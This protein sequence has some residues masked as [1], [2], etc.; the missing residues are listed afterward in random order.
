MYVI[1]MIYRLGGAVGFWGGDVRGWTTLEGAER[2]TDLSLAKRDERKLQLNYYNV[3]IV[4]IISK[5][6]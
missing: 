2:Y 6:R 3:N 1:S 4:Q 5:D